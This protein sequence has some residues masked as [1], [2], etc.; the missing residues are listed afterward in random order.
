MSE[1]KVS[2]FARFRMWFSSLSTVKKTALLLAVFMVL[3]A[4]AAGTTVWWYYNRITD[5]DR[6]FPELAWPGD[7]VN[8]GDLVDEVFG[9][10]TLNI[11]LMG[12]DR[13]DDR[14]ESGYG[15]NPDTLMVAAISFDTGQVNLVSIPRDTL[16][17]LTHAL[18]GRGRINTS[19]Y[20]GSARRY[21]GLTNPLE[22]HKSGIRKVIDTVSA[23][24]KGVPIH[25]YVAVDMQ[26]AQEIVDTLGGI[27]YD[28]EQNIY[29]SRG[30]IR[31]RAGYQKL[32][33]EKFLIYTRNRRYFY[34]DFRRVENQQNILIAAYEQF[35]ES[36]KLLDAPNIFKSVQNHLETSLSLE[37]IAA[38]SF[39]GAQNITKEDIQTHT[40]PGG[41]YGGRVH[42]SQV[43]TRYYV[44]IDQQGRA[45][46]LKEVWGL[47]VEPDPTD[48]LLPPLP[49]ERPDEDNGDADNNEDTD[50]TQAEGDAEDAE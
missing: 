20:F 17:P 44:I 31:L 47:E 22:Q 23:T 42:H 9:A 29:D 26:G 21:T 38:L 7:S 30:N 8:E 13:D 49:R 19:Y 3:S 46:L 41:S 37:Q 36:G 2:M 14:D 33:G 40:L 25:H 24:L 48:T 4:G 11:L 34:G 32:D 27:W 1:E 35:R 50:D 43:T 15:V 5:M 39:F 6:M 16:V 45:D 12:F 10:K 28:V 18:G